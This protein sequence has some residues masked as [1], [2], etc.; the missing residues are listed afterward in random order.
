LL[1]SIPAEVTVAAL[2]YLVVAATI[3]PHEASHTPVWHRS[4][5][6]LPLFSPAGW[7][8]TLVSLPLLL[9]LT[10]GWVWRLALWTRLLWLISR[11]D[12][13][14]VASHPDR[15]GGLSFVGH[16]VRA[17]AVVALALATIVAG[18]SAHTVLAGG[19]LP[20]PQLHFNIG[21]MATIM[22]LFVAPLLAFTPTLVRARRRGAFEY[23]ALAN[24]LGQSFER[25]WLG[26]GAAVDAGSLEQPDFSAT[27]DLYQVA[28]NVYA[29]RFVPVEPK[30]LLPLAVAMLLPFAPV[31]LLAVPF[32]VILTQLKRLLV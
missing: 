9:C 1:D 5:G 18:R 10:L 8:H 23:G 26:P 24:R 12:L 7:W 32:E 2:A 6:A 27:T 3:Y 13:R 11:L 19:G 30:D 20:T 31:V 21:V 16:S 14:L 17:F 4:A 22:A 25:K 15:A 28:S 29:I